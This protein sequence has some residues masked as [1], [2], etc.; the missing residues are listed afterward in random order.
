MT[1]EKAR[2]YAIRQVGQIIPLDKETCEELINYTLTLPDH[3]IESHLLDILGPSDDTFEL[4]STFMDYK[5]TEDELRKM[6]QEKQKTKAR[7]VTEPVPKTKTGPAWR[8]HD[9]APK[10]APKARL[11]GNKSSVTTSQL[12]DEKPSN[13][14]SQS[15]VKKT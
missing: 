10:S 12:A 7:L 15:Q 11:S 13:K 8:K 4:I 2:A 1:Y 14:L 3:E 5:R 6:Q 9:E